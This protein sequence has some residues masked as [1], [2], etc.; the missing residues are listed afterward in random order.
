MGTIDH[1]IRN[2]R[3]GHKL[4]EP[5]LPRRIVIVRREASESV[6]LFAR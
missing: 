2:R 4:N 1:Q 6:L 5:Q 3:D